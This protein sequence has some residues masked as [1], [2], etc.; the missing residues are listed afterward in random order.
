MKIGIF[1]DAHYSSKEV[2]D[3]NRYN[4]QSLRKIKE[5]YE[6]FE[7]EGCKLV[8]SLGDLIE[9]DDDHAL[10]VN[11]LKE[12]AEIISASPIP[13]VC[14]MGNHDAFT[15]GKKEYY[16][17]LGIG[18]ARDLNIGDKSFIFLDACFHASGERYTTGGVDWRDCYLPDTEELSEVLESL[19]EDS[20]VF[21]H[22]NI[23]P[24]LPEEYKLSNC[25]EVFAMIS[26]TPLVKAVFQGHYHPG[27]ISEYDGVKYYALP[28]MC[29][30]EDRAF[31]FDL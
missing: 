25:D 10:E 26:S 16:S 11:N 3:G 19:S 7:E 21:I 30:G 4:K 13:T 8:I 18:E 2:V 24:A 15:F 17:T 1:A 12:I 14:L 23:D 29:E 20:Y 28:A 31:V 6:F 22:H 27:K 5:A 9:G